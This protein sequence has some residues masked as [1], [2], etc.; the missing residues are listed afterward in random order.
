MGYGAVLEGKHDLAKPNYQYE[1]RQRELAK[2]A[3]KAEK[4]ARKGS[5]RADDPSLEAGA[6]VPADDGA[7]Q[8]DAGQAGTPGDGRVA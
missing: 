6:E 4:A 8:P 3:K 2:K 7:T 5:A 1:K